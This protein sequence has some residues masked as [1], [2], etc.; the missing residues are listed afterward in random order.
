[1]TAPNGARRAYGSLH[2]SLARV[3]PA[4]V[5]H[6]LGISAGFTRRSYAPGAT[7]T[8]RV[9]TDE[10]GFTLQLLQAGPETQETT[11][12]EMAGVPLTE[13]QVVDW[14][15]HRNT[16][17]ALSEKLGTWPSGIYFARL[18]T[19]EG[20]SYYAPL[21]MR[22]AWWGVN[23]IAVVIHTNTWQAYNFQ[24]VNGDGWGDTWYASDDIHTVD[25]SRAYVGLGAPPRWRKY[26]LPFLHWLYRSGKL[27]D[28]VTDDDLRRFPNAAELARRYDLIVFPGYDEYETRHVYDLVTGYRNLGGNLIFLSATNF[29]WKVH[30]HGTRITRIAE[31]RQLGRPEAGLVGVEYRGND[32][33]QHHG[34]YVLSRFGR[35]SWALAGIDPAALDAWHWFGIEYDMTTR[36]SPRGIH[37]LGRVNPHMRNRWLRGEM[38]YYQRGGAKVFAAGTLNFP[39]ALV[40]P[41]FRQLLENVWQRLAVP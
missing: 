38:T 28:F 39:A 20:R 19:P 26:D 7:A 41:Q 27:V 37:V 9:A 8:L 10:Q 25:L 40:Y 13:P 35:S 12:G 30:R 34:H 29:L 17:A 16:P 24:D 32:E 21:V 18:E 33:G 6:V 2:H 1:V 5:V 14:S 23:R 3:D 4:P 36:A 31:W 15:G 22:P 11:G